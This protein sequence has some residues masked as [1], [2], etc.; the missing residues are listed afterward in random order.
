MAEISSYFYELE[1]EGEITSAERLD[2]NFAQHI[3]TVVRRGLESELSG[4]EC[5]K[6]VRELVTEIIDGEIE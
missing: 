2:A 6:E 3:R 5:N 1:H 4:D